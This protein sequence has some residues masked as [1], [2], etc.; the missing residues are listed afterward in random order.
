MMPMSCNNLS[1]PP[2]DGGCHPLP[3]CQH[4]AFS[5]AV[6]MYCRRPA[7]RRFVSSAPRRRV[8]SSAAVA[9]AATHFLLPW[10]QQYLTTTPTRC[11]IQF[12]KKDK[13]IYTSQGSHFPRMLLPEYQME[14]T[15]H[16]GKATI[17]STILHSVWRIRCRRHNCVPGGLSVSSC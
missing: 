17:A 9:A 7:D 4:D 6:A 13:R 14:D 5:A 1:A 2:A 16:I 3:R 8:L 11:Q 12:Q 10:R 15:C